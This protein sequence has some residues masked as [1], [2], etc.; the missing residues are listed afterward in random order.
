M[1]RRPSIKGSHLIKRIVDEALDI[2][3]K[4]DPPHYV[5]ICQN[6]KLINATKDTHKEGI[7]VFAL[8]LGN[9]KVLLTNKLYNDQQRFTP[10]Y[11]AGV[12]THEAIH[13]IDERYKFIYQANP[14]KRERIAFENQLL[15]LK[16]VKAPLWVIDETLEIQRQYV[17]KLGIDFIAAH[18]DE[19]ERK[20]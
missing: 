9:G 11:L 8:M 14:A 12:L 18:I 5:M 1:L 13:A 3:E 17:K 2:L 6:I 15:A 10:Q 19:M 16:L 4:H 7:E 20:R